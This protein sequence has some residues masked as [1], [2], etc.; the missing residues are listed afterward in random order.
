MCGQGRPLGGNARADLVRGVLGATEQ[1]VPKSEGA[2]NCVCLRNSR[3]FCVARGRE[4]MG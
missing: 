1:Q 2:Q 4:Q 3:K